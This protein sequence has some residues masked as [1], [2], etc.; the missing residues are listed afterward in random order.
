MKEIILIYSNVLPVSNKIINTKIIDKIIKFCSIYNIDFKYINIIDNFNKNLLIKHDITKL[1]TLLINDGNVIK[2]SGINNIKKYSD[3]LLIQDET[4]IKVKDLF[5]DKPIFKYIQLNKIKTEKFNDYDYVFTNINI[6][7]D[8]LQSD[9]VIFLNEL[10][11]DNFKLI[12]PKLFKN[13]KCL[14]ISKNIVLKNVVKFLYDFIINNVTYDEL[15]KKY[16]LSDEIK[17]SLKKINE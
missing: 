15:I 5:N 8:S 2:L 3:L 4:E 16:N 1:P 10:D 7:D 9:N 12:T 13:N 11:T 14:I 6:V 17:Y